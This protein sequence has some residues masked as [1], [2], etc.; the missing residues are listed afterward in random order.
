MHFRIFLVFAKVCGFVFV[1]DAPVFA[2]CSV[3]MSF[4]AAQQFFSVVIGIIF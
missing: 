3:F 2:S 1:D 4:A